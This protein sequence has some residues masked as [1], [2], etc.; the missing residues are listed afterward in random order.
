MAKT[1]KTTI[2]RPNRPRRVLFLSAA[3][4]IGGAE[5]SLY[6]LVC[7]LPKD[8]VEAHVCVPSESP[9][10]RLFA[11]AGIPV[12]PVPL[13]RF[14]RSRNP[15]V[16]AGQLRALH[17]GAK[18]IGELAGQL[19]LDLLHANTDATALVAWEV[20]RETGLPFVWHCRDLRPL[21]LLAKILAGA[22]ACAVAISEAVE[23]HL[24]QQ[25]VKRER[26]RRMPNGID[27]T[28]FHAPEE[29]AAVR[30]R[31]RGYLGISPETPLLI[32]IG[33][34]VPWKRHELF[35]D[36][37]AEIR[38]HRPDVVG[39]LVGSDLFHENRA[40]VSQLERHAERLRLSDGGLLVLQQREDVPDLL[41]ASDILISTSD[42][43]PFGRVLVEAGASGVPVVCTDSG[44][45][46]EIVVHNETGLLTPPGDTQAL[47]DA[48]L[49]LLSAPDRRAA[50]A[51]AG[52][53]LA[54]KRF[55]VRRL[56]LDVAKLYDE[57][58]A[59]Q[60]R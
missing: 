25:G 10:S 14:R 35:L 26:V 51:A 23:N 58:L 43:E 4:R 46:R 13:R 45:K 53:D 9:L 50:M 55:D 41:T 29:R 17:L 37:L 18:S 38:K 42:N 44:A 22:T 36:A 19:G 24:L 2:L 20:S 56:A 52:R 40:Y 47:A 49:E 30:T 28:R 54:A 60:K 32:D 27:L 7:A 31:T 33:A 8:Q 12:H 59:T 15:L 48:C 3:E 11:L 16:L 1:R 34:W 5:R 39:L 21:G 6:E 57:L